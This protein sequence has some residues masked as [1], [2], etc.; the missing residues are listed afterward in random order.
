[1][2]QSYNTRTNGQNTEQASEEGLGFIMPM[3]AVNSLGPW[4]PI[5]FSSAMNPADPIR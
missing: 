2:E 1:M 5:Y 3:S 4:A